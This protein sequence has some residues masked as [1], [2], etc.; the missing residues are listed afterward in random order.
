L[1]RRD[2]AATIAQLAGRIGV[3]ATAVRQRLARLMDQGLVDRRS[4][5][6]GRG[7]PTY[8]YSLSPTG[9]R[10]AGDNYATLA[11]ALW[12]ELRLIADPAVKRGLIGR[13][14]DRIAAEARPHVQGGTLAER[15][16]SL[17]EWMQQRD[18]PF[19]A[20]ER[21]AGRQPAADGNLGASDG[22]KPSRL[23]GDLGDEGSSETLRV[24]GGDGESQRQ[25]LS[26]V[27]AGEG[28]SLPVLAAL[29]CPYPELAE[30]DR[31]VC[32]V[33]RMALANVLGA[34]LQ[35]TSCRLDGGTC[36]TFEASPAKAVS[37]GSQP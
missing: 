21:P 8:E 16:R 7:R 28:Q 26:A 13:L 30:Q 37:V 25:G 19:E 36:C 27:A 3:T 23:G 35:L 2:P 29:A 6:T 22:G 1:L 15:M 11:I 31:A 4:R 18:I 9:N 5:S 12:Q 32:A 33:E 17:A 14:A 10:L 24:A 20:L 34:P